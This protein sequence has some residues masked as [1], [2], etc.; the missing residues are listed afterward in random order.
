ME[1]MRPVDNHNGGVEAQ[2]GAVEGRPVVADSPHFHEEQ[3]PD[4]NIR[5]FEKSRNWSETDTH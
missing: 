3:D 5:I 2:N 1:P 4:L